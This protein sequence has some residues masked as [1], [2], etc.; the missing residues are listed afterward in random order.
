[1]IQQS[2]SF[3][4]GIESV[5]GIGTPLCKRED[6]AGLSLYNC[7]S[8]EQDKIYP[9]TVSE[10]AGAQRSDRVLKIYFH[11]GG[12]CDSSK[13]SFE[14]VNDTQ[15]LVNKNAKMVIPEALKDKILDWYHHHLQHPGHDRL[16]AAINAT[17]TW[18]GLKDS[19]RRYTKK[20][21][22]CQKNKHTKKQYG[23]LP[24]KLCETKPWHTLC[25]D[26]MGPYTIKGKNK[27]ELYFMCLTM[28][29]PATG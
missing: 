12:K 29:D 14:W 18:K 24:E 13:Y 8:K 22:K 19:V 15:V 4:T 16:E 21:P 3:S 28:I 2:F 27:S 20:C 1:M 23:K 5:H 11:H 6:R 25:V 9:P 17:M 10:I 7:S 26:L